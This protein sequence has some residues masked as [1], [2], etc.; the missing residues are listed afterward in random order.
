M[1]RLPRLDSCL[2]VRWRLPNRLSDTFT[3][4]VLE[5]LRAAFGAATP[6]GGDAERLQVGRPRRRAIRSSAITRPTDAWRWPRPGEEPA[7]TGLAG[8][9][10]VN[11]EPMA[12]P[13]EVAGPGFLNVRL[14]EEWILTPWPTL[15]G[16][17]RPGILTARAAANGRHRL[18][19]AQR[20]QADARR[21][22]PLD[23]DRRQPGP[24]L[25]GPRAITSSA[26]TTWATGARS[27][28]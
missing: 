1:T 16:D 28:A 9:R 13:P 24:D 22:Y 25:R 20:R 17:E 7:R 27:S 5:R 2:S 8:R 3:M 19:F 23:R 21:P 6:E 11:L 18:L 14:H 26:T 15:L 12:G 10:A 4:N